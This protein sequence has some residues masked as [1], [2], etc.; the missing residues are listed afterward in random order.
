ME[1]CIGAGR[2]GEENDWEKNVKRDPVDET[3]SSSR[4][5]KGA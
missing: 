1:I 3:K 2:C 4:P 5:R